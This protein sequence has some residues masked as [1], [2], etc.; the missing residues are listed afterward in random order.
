[1]YLTAPHPDDF[2]V[3]DVAPV[4]TVVVRRR[5]V[6]GAQ[7]PQLYDAA[8]ARISAATKFGD[9]IAHGP[10]FSL[11]R[12]LGDTMDVDIGVPGVLTA[13]DPNLLVSELPGGTLA[14]LSYRGPQ[15]QLPLAWAEFSARIAGQ[16]LATIGP[17]WE[18]YVDHPH[19]TDLYSVVA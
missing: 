16:G 12:S 18:S 13:V 4:A 8:L 17:T 5:A 10:P 9:V 11:F 6:S 3:F 2:S 14:R 7:V 1:M 19:R 15:E